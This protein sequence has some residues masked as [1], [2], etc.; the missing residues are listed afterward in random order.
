MAKI[1]VRL[2]FIGQSNEMNGEK[3][4]EAKELSD[5]TRIIRDSYP[6]DYY[7]FLIF[8]NG[9]KIEDDHARMDDGDE[10]VVTP[11]FSGG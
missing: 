5:V 10:V 1:H 7:T 2:N 8:K 11:V 3:T 9:V 6:L 4:I